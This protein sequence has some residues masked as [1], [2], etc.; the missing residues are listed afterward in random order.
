VESINK[1]FGGNTTTAF[2]LG[3]SVE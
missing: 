2:H 3:Q 1:L